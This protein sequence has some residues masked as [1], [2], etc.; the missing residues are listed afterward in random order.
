MSLCDK[1]FWKAY[2]RLC[3]MWRQ[4]FE[5]Q[6]GGDYAIFLVSEKKYRDVNFPE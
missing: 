5:I 4:E 1:L 6:H 3:E 2:P